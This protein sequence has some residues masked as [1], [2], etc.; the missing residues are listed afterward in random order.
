MYLSA[1]VHVRDIEIHTQILQ[2]QHSSLEYTVH[3]KEAIAILFS[4]WWKVSH[5][6]LLEKQWISIVLLSELPLIYISNVSLA[7]RRKSIC[8][9]NSGSQQ[10]CS[11]LFVCFPVLFPHRQDLSCS[12]T[13]RS[14]YTCASRP[15]FAHGHLFVLPPTIFISSFPRTNK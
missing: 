3:M 13:H 12:Y 6:L 7:S 15:S 5:H 14:L 10:H 9:R 11:C 2:S 8:K 4:R 1:C